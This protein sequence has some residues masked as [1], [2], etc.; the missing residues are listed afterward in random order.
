MV[1]AAEAT[2]PVIEQSP[3]KLTWVSTMDIIMAES[4]Y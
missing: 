1:D 3:E 4:V 2:R